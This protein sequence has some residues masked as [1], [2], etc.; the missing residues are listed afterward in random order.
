[1]GGHY[2]L[3]DDLVY[4]CLQNCHIAPQ[5]FNSLHGCS[6]RPLVPHMVLLFALV[7]DE[8]GAELVDGVVGEMHAHVLLVAAVWFFVRAGGQPAQSLVIDIN[9]Q[10][11]DA[12]HQDVYPEIEFHAL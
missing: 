8:V 2:S 10:G 11:S 6:V 1:M 7:E 3:D 5:S 4:L 12:P 9:L